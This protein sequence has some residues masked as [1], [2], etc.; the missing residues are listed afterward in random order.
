M[1]PNSC[2]LEMIV[3]PEAR[4]GRQH[5]GVKKTCPRGTCSNRAP[6]NKVLF[7]RAPD[8]AISRSL[9]SRQL[10]QT[11][12][13]THCLAQRSS[14]FRLHLS[15]AEHELRDAVVYAQSSGDT[16]DRFRSDFLAENCHLRKN[17]CLLVGIV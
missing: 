8:R 10:P 6:Y 14:G 13:D 1:R 2:P 4:R 16:Q 5:E 15:P 17:V 11:R 12:G 7:L 3:V 9:Y